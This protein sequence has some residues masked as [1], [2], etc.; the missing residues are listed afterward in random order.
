MFRPGVQSS[1]L[2]VPGS[3]GLIKAVPLV[4]SAKP[5]EYPGAPS[6]PIDCLA[7]SPKL[8]AVPVWRLAGLELRYITAWFPRPVRNSALDN[9]LARTFVSADAT[10]GLPARA[11]ESAL[12]P[13]LRDAYAASEG[14]IARAFM[15]ADRDPEP[16]RE[17][18]LD[19]ATSL[20][21]ALT[22]AFTDAEIEDPVDPSS[23]AETLPLT[24]CAIVVPAPKT[25][26]LHSHP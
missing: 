2:A 10:P 17:A 23:T 16:D 12:I 8:C 4:L 1:G 9:R 26:R 3:G 13:V 22:D 21:P 18:E 15:D 5:S 11:A 20:T 7:G 25:T 6:S 19:G 24:L 14:L